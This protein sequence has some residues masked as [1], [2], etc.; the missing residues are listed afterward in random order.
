MS[1]S[2]AFYRAIRIASRLPGLPLQLARVAAAV[3]RLP[4]TV[5]GVRYEL[6]ALKGSMQV[7]PELLDEFEQWKATT[8]IPENP[9]VSVCVATFDRPNLL[10]DRCLPRS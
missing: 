8:P 6:D 5:T 1:I 10:V 7:R 3:Y 4:Q 9:L 2:E